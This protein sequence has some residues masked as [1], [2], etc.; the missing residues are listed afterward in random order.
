M[1]RL[2]KRLR[3]RNTRLPR[4]AIRRS[5]V[6]RSSPSPAAALVSPSITRILSRS[7]C[8]RPM[9]HVPVFDSPR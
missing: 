3:I 6:P 1:G 9:N 7:V 8:N 4:F 2:R 5:S